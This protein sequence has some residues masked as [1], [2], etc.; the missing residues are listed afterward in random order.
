MALAR[1]LAAEP[2]L[3]LLDEPLA[4]L[5]AET[6]AQVRTELSRHLAEFPGPTLVITHD[7]LEAMV[8]TD[9]LL[10]IE[11]G[12]VVQAGAAGRGREPGRPPSTWP[13]WSD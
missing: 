10:V 7:P 6:R 12:R 1:A 5:D 3:L 11:A 8:M 13:G 2:G 9:R 4:A